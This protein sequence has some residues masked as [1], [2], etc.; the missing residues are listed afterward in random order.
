[1]EKYSDGWLFQKHSKQELK[2]WLQ[3]LKY[4]YF[5]RAW[6]GH[7]NDGDLFEVAFSYNDRQDL[8]YKIGQI[9]LT[10]NTIPDNFPKPVIGQAYSW[11]EYNKFK[12]EIDEFNDLEQPGHSIIFEIIAFITVRN[13]LIHFTISGSADDNPYEVT[14][15]DLKKCIILEQH[16]DT[17]GWQNF[18]DKSM[19]KNFNYISKTIY[20]ELY[21]D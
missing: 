16:F 15:D 21:E 4:F 1:M 7:A 11:E 8:L 18:K 6:G 9:G 20:P 13:K 12:S 14:E 2:D 17:L 3:K 10:L 5:K 19:E